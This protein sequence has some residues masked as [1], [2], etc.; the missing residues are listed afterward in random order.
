MMKTPCTA[1]ASALIAAHLAACVL[2]T[3]CSHAQTPAAPASASAAP[4]PQGLCNA[5]P[6]QFVLGKSSTESVVE[7][8]RL[9]SGA[10]K[11]R[12]LRPGQRITKEFDTQRLNLE[13]D[14]GGRIIAVDCG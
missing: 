5:G 4:A 14:D 7:S 9:R 1:A 12:I 2:L 11:A 10:H 6:A 3:G 8:A 13:V